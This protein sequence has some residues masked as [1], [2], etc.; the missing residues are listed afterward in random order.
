MAVGYLPPP[1][2]IFALGV[3]SLPNAPNP[4]A[5]SFL[6][7]ILLCYFSVASAYLAHFV[8]AALGGFT[9]TLPLQIVL[10][11]PPISFASALPLTICFR[12]FSRVPTV[13]SF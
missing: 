10:C 11:A 6:P 12:V 9:Q 8:G 1:L 4:V 2:A 13:M 7:F 3:S 5:S